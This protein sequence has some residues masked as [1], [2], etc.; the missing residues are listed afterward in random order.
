MKDRV[1]QYPHRY[2][3]VPVAG[4]T[5]VYDFVPVTGTVT[6]EGTPL[7]KANLLSD[8]T[9]DLLGLIGGEATVNNAL[10][11]NL[12]TFGVLTSPETDQGVVSVTLP[13][14]PKFVLACTI[15]NPTMMVVQGIASVEITG[16]SSSTYQIHASL[17]GATFSATWQYFENK[18]SVY[19]VAFI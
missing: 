7:N 3:L 1:V 8:T 5:G 14:E 15:S 16:N 2:Q 19:Y 13:F 11:K 18:R 12:Q 9:A 17:D 6:E 4:E 10:V